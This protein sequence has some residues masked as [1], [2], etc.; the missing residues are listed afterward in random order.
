METQEEGWDQSQ[1]MNFEQAGSIL[2]TMG[3]LPENVTPERPD[4]KLFEELW[5]LL[6]GTAREGVKADD[7]KYILSIIRGYRDAAREIDCQPIEGKQGVA[8]MIVFDQ[9]ANF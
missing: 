6:E 1:M 4:Y 7:L 3:F 5:E 9:E 8:K 2:A